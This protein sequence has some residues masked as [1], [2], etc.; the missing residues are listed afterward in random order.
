MSQQGRLRQ[1][2]LES[3]T[4]DTGGPVFPD[5]SDNINIVG[6][7]T[8]VVNGNPGTNTLTIDA[9]INGYP[10]TPYVVGPSGFA[11]YQT[12]QSAIDAIGAGGSGQIWIQPGT[13]TEDLVFPDGINCGLITGS[14]EDAGAAEIV[15]VHTPPLTGNV[16]LWR[17]K[18]TSSTHIFSSNAAGSAALVCSH[19]NY[20]TDGYIF[21][22]PN[23][24]SS[25][26][27]TTFAIGDFLSTSDGIVNNTGGASV[28]L[29]QS[30]LGVGTSNPCILSGF[31]AI[32]LM[33]INCPM[34]IQSAASCQ[35]EYSTFFQPLTLTGSSAGYI[36]SCRIASAGDPSLTYN[37]TGNFEVS[38]VNLNSSN[39][40]CIAG[41]GS[42]T[43]SL[44]G[45]NFEDNSNI[46]G[47]LTVSGGIQYSSIYKSDYTDHGVILGQGTLENMVATAAGTDGQLLIGA[48]GADPAFSD[49]TSTGGTITITPGPN[50]LNVE[51]GAVVPTTFDTDS[52]SAV[53]AANNLDILGT[54]AQGISTSGA[55]NVVTI[56][57]SDASTTQK[58]V[59]ETST[60]AES[61][62]GASTTVAVTP[63]SLAAKLGTQTSNGLAYGGGTTA[64]VN[65]LGEA[66]D[67]QLPIGN[68]GSAPTLATLTAGVGIT[69]T[70]GSGSITIDADNGAMDWNEITVTGP[71]GMAVDNGY[72][73]NNA[74]VVGLTLPATSAIGDIIKVDGKGAGGWS[75]GQNAGQTIHF[76]AQDTTTGAAGSLASTGQYDCVTLRCIT[77]NTDFVVETSVGNITVT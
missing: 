67:G 16:V 51:A 24:T 1:D 63:A 33:D 31:T 18:M 60:D 11:G 27:L 66:I 5:A 35:I 14:D 62:A 56:T 50:T 39:N 4:G 43:I 61:I 13:Y 19:N 54:A 29:F 48:T 15:G 17:I 26:S 53:P 6:G 21:N 44:N 73:A 59:I 57:A 32:Q 71:T 10:V 74:G 7:D 8:T 25:G 34:T 47:T 45:V 2:A 64:A 49:L 22:L 55:T 42:G 58:G 37:T 36:T 20:S 3:L 30:G 41:T 38:G 40:P 9:S 69:I 75:I 12:V 46:A 68:T 70:N 52:G 72:I 23:W 77:A 28:F 76:L 65:W